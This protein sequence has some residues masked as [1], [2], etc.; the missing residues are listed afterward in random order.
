MK[1]RQ[2]S[3]F[4]RKAAGVLVL[5]AVGAGI[6]AFVLA[7]KP[8]DLTAPKE[9]RP[10]PV[11]TFVA[12]LAPSY[13]VDRAFAGRIVAG[14]TS[15]MGFE[16]SGLLAKV[17]VDDGQTVKAGQ[18]VAQLDTTQLENRRGELMADKAEAVARLAQAKLILKRQ[19]ELL[20][21]GHTAQQTFDNSKY[22]VVALSAKLSRIDAALATL[23]SDIG[24]SVLHAPFAGKV[25]DRKADEGTVVAAGQTV[26]EIYETGR[27]EARIGVPADMA[28]AMRSGRRFT[29][30]IGGVAGG[31]SRGAVV[32]T[33]SPTV[34]VSTRTVN[35]ILRLDPGPFVPAGQIVRLTLPRKFAQPGFWVP[36]TALSEG[37]RGLWTLFAVVDGKVRRHAV[38]VLHVESRRVFVRGTLADGNILIRSG[39]HR[40]VPGQAVKVVPRPAQRAAT[41]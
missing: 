10:L 25:A 29:L 7:P 27:Q 20:K 13:T 23:A 39:L 26:V 9:A 37:T 36:T 28:A 11:V 12:R 33:V 8:G 6:A 38:E 15:R 40:L 35:A 2:Y 17:L 21:K 32:T 24:K 41:D 18:V 4:F 34:D 31:M 30:E 16:R 3:R 14:R 19:S 22:E 5:A 1:K